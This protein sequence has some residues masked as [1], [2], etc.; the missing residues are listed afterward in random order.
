MFLGDFPSNSSRDGTGWVVVAV[1]LLALLII[2][3][4]IVAEA[5]EFYRSLDAILPKRAKELVRMRKLMCKMAPCFISEKFMLPTKQY[6]LRC[7]YDEIDLHLTFLEDLEG[8]C[9]PIHVVLESRRK[10]IQIEEQE[11]EQEQVEDGQKESETEHVERNSLEKNASEEEEEKD[12]TK[13]NVVFID[14]AWIEVAKI[15]KRSVIY[16]DTFRQLLL[17]FMCDAHR[18]DL[19]RLQHLTEL[20]ETNVINAHLERK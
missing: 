5:I 15:L 16:S 11:D 19:H 8:R 6:F 1:I 20:F 2:V 9:E 18:K 7:K 13:G 14:G 10:E 4:V 3:L 17:E 12:V